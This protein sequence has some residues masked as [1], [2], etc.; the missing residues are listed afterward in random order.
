MLFQK[1]SKTERA[2][3]LSAGLQKKKE[4][5]ERT[6]VVYWRPCGGRACGRTAIAEVKADLE[7]PYETHQHIV[8]AP[9]PTSPPPIIPHP[10][11]PLHFGTEL[12][13]GH[14]CSV[15]ASGWMKRLETTSCGVQIGKGIICHISPCVYLSRPERD[16]VTASIHRYPCC[17]P[18]HCC[19]DY[20][21]KVTADCRL[22]YKSN[23]IT[24]MKY[25]VS[26]L[27]NY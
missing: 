27:I 18:A 17:W 25:F 23:L 3:L 14:V 9:T 12:S 2:I 16:C 22:L 20:S 6:R 11:V 7:E 15:C 19:W 21:I 1:W 24:L 4:K 8:S 5:K 10:R 26:K 13:P